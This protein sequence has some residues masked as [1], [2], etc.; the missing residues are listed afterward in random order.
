MILVDTSI[1]IDHLARPNAKLSHLFEKREV[2][3]HP[4]VIGEI[5]LGSLK[6]RGAVL[7]QMNRLPRIGIATLSEVAAM[8]EWDK[9][10]GTGIRYVDA[11]LLAATRLANETRLWTRD[12]RLQAQAQRFGVAATP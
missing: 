1:W 7:K 5:A 4:F 2:L 3:T 9:L 10:H 8:I 11:H 12:Q 6:D